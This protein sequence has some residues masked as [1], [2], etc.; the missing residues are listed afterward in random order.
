MSVLTDR[1]KIGMLVWFCALVYFVSYVS[2]I[3]LSAVLVEVIGS[4]FAEKHSAA[5]AL[6]VCSITYGA[7]QIISGWLGDRF[8]PQNVIFVGFVITAAVNL[9]VGM[10]PDGTYL[11]ALWA[12]NGFAQAFMWPPLVK[13]LST[14]LSAEEYK[15]GCVKVSWGS[16]LG[17]IAVYLAAP[18]LITIV[19]FRAVFL[20]SGLLAVTMAFL[21]KALYGRIAE[22]NSGSAP[23]EKTE[24]KAA[25]ETQKRDDVSLSSFVLILLGFIMLAIILQGMLRDGVTNWMPTL[26]AETFALDSSVSIL[27]GVVLPIFSIACYQLTSWINRAL[28]TNE[29]VCAGIIFFAGFTAAVLLAL[30]GSRSVVLSLF[31]LAVL[32]GSM[33]GVNLILVCMIPPFFAKYGRVSL[34]S[35]IINSCTY[36]G[37][38]I[39]TY[40]IAV[41][42]DRFGWV[43]TIYLWAVIALAGTLICL[44]LGKGWRRFAKL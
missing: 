43:S 11:A 42:T 20:C 8:R 6:T 17:T 3:N 37:S 21:W 26:M 27:T 34:I 18:I 33:H 25:E 7:G 23:A 44:S 29:V 24:K 30:L 32:V 1:K 40:G 2:R 12:V 4:G 16:S 39:S 41:Y 10:I 38:A 31:L 35:G 15:K 13:I 28:I 22:E 14:Q 36:V 5:L 9:C 19:S